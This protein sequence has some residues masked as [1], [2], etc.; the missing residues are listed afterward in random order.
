MLVYLKN[1]YGYTTIGGKRVYGKS[2]AYGTMGPTDIGMKEWEAHK[3]VLEEATYSCEWLEKHF[4]LNKRGFSFTFS[5]LKKIPFRELVLIAKYVGV[6]YVGPI[7]TVGSIKERNSL[8]KSIGI[9]L[10]PLR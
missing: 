7:K 9:R 1:P 2:Y 8:I 4:G 5:D 6:Q 10:E 3:D